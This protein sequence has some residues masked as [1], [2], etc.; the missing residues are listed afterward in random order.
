MIIFLAVAKSLMSALL[1]CVYSLIVLLTAN[2]R[3][4]LQLRYVVERTLHL[5]GIIIQSCASYIDNAVLLLQLASIPIIVLLS[6]ITFPYEN[7]QIMRHIHETIYVT[8]W[9][10]VVVGELF[11]IP[12]FFIAGLK[13]IAV[14]YGIKTAYIIV[15]IIILG[16]LFV[17]MNLIILRVTVDWRATIVGIVFD[18]VFV[19]SMLVLGCRWHS[20]WPTSLII[21]F[22]LT[23][24]VQLV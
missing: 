10:D 19:T 1:I 4:K 18:I 22:P 21:L 2:D 17:M 24:E 16:L 9:Y 3:A 13:S 23:I 12:L 6:I 7:S 11:L 5:A 20:G 14:G 15:S 8:F